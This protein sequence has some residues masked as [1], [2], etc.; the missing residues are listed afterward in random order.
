MCKRW[1]PKLSELTS[2]EISIEFTPVKSIMS[3]NE[4]PEGIAVE[5]LVLLQ[6]NIDGCADPCGLDCLR[7]RYMRARI[8][9]VYGPGSV[10]ADSRCR[11]LSTESAPRESLQRPARLG[12]G[13]PQ[14]LAARVPGQQ[15]FV[16]ILPGC[17]Q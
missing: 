7:G 9:P 12:C 11:T 15:P 5:V 13:K 10:G 6:D 4:T 8:C 2:G 17:Y 16:S 14:L 1:L 3:R